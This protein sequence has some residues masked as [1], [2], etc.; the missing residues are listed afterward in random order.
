MNKSDLA[1][2]G[3]DWS[4]KGSCCSSGGLQFLLRPL[5]D[6]DDIFEATIYTSTTTNTTTTAHASAIVVTWKRSGRRPFA[7]NIR[8]L[9]LVSCLQFRIALDL[10]NKIEV[11]KEEALA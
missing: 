9:L 11:R 6:V 4:R 8:Q 3:H 5:L 7:T 10:M 1:G 2:C